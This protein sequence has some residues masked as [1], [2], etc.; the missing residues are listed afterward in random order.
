MTT[1][2]YVKSDRGILIPI[3]GPPD[4]RP[5][6]IKVPIRNG[7]VN[8]DGAIIMLSATIGATREMA[9]VIYRKFGYEP[10]FIEIP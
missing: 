9:E 1:L 3:Q 10:E 4:K 7:K 5:K 6:K 8:P 2:D